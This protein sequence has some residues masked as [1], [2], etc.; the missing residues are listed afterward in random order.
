VEFRDLF[1]RNSQ[2]CYSCRWEPR[3]PYQG[4][5]IF[6]RKRQ[7]KNSTLIKYKIKKLYIKK[8]KKFKMTNK[9]NLIYNYKLNDITFL[10]E[11]GKK[12]TT[13][14]SW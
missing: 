3:I 7:K 13:T 12:K 11:K 2:L 10:K 1:L 8:V 5:T 6:K 4:D 14:M 9:K